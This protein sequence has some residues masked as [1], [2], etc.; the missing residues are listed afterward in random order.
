LSAFRVDADALDGVLVSRSSAMRSAPCRGRRPL[1][2]REVREQQGA[3]PT[4]D[5]TV[6]AGAPGAPTV[7]SPAL[8]APPTSATP[9]LVIFPSEPEPDERTE[10]IDAAPMRPSKRGGRARARRSVL[11]GAC[12]FV[13]AA[14]ASFGMVAAVSS[15]DSRRSVAVAAHDPGPARAQPGTAVAAPPSHQES[16]LSPA[17]TSTTGTSTSATETS[18]SLERESATGPAAATGW[19]ETFP[20]AFRNG[21]RS[22]VVSSPAEVERLAAAIR[23]CAGVA[24][25]E[26]H[27][28]DVGTRDYNIR[29]GRDRARRVK[30]Q[31]EAAGIE[32]TRMQTASVGPDRPIADNGTDAGQAANRRVTITCE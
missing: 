2:A 22:P 10:L 19:T 14:A 27:T 6:A 28:S 20:A 5:R 23:E 29:L 17:Q 9:P 3:A 31:L 7:A 26:G 24:T 30:A 32:R 8:P 18:P 15:G 21:S 4:P 13:T 16:S 25:I 1:A 11:I 12:L